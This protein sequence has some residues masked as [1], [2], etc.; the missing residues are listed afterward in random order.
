[1]SQTGK[2]NHCFA[3]ASVLNFQFESMPGMRRDAKTEML[4]HRRRQR[5]VSGNVWFGLGTTFAPWSAKNG[6]EWM[7]EFV[8]IIN[9]SGT[10]KF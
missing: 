2:E 8:A 1:M 3:L 4:W 7:N 6:R 10:I 5:E 9:L